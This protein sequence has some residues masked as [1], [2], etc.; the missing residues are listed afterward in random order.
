MA[1]LVVHLVVEI[2]VQLYLVGLGPLD[3]RGLAQPD[4]AGCVFEAHA[5][6]P[7]LQQLAHEVLGEG[8]V[9]APGR[10]VE[11]YLA[12]GDLLDGGRVVLGFKGS[13][14][15]DHPEDSDS[16][17]PQ[18]DPLVVASS[19]VH[20]RSLV[21]VSADHG[22][23]VPA[24]SSLVGLFADAE[25]DEL[26][27]PADRTVEYI[28]GLDVAVAYIPVVQILQR[29]DQLLDHVLQL[30]LGG[31]EGVAEAG[32]VEALHDEEGAVLA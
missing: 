26:Y 29:L 8:A 22:Q 7:Q 32:L 14:A 20:F 18:I 30:L 4:V 21:V 19:E 28:L 24:H 16:Q 11:A 17:G 13:V 1:Q 3:G 25:V 6:L 12:L 27:C 31:E 10:V 23:H 15:G 5:F 9:A 2:D